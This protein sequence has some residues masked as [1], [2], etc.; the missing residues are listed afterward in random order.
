MANKKAVLSRPLPDATVPRNAFDRESMRV[1]HYSLGQIIPAWWEVMLKGSHAKF[2]RKIF[3]RTCSLKTAAFPIIDTHIEYYFVP[4]RQL[5]S[6]W[7]DFK[8]G[9][10]DVNS[11]ALV[12]SADETSLGALTMPNRVP[13]T[14]LTDIYAALLNMRT[15]SQT[16]IFGQPT[17]QNAEKLLNLLGYGY[18]DAVSTNVA[19]VNLWPLL[20]YHKI[21]YDHKRNSM[22]ENN[23]A[24][25]YNMDYLW[26]RNRD[27]KLP[28]SELYQNYQGLLT[29]HY[30]DY[31]NDYFNNIYPSLTYIQIT[32][33]YQTSSGTSGNPYINPIGIPSSV[34]GMGSSSQSVTLTGTTGSDYNRWYQD[35]SSTPL[36]PSQ[37]VST[38]SDS[39]LGTNGYNMSHDH[40]LNTTATITMQY[41][42]QSMRAAFALDKLMR[43]SAYA[44]QH[45][46]EQ[47]EARFGV[48]SKPNPN[49]SIF[50]GAYKNDIQIG[51]VTST[52][53]TSASGGDALGAIGGKGVGFDDWGKTLEFT[54]EE[55]GIVMAIQYSTI[56]SCYR[57]AGI[58][59][60]L[61]KHLP[62]DYFVPEFMNMGLEPVY[63]LEFNQSLG[64][65][66]I[67]GFR[68]RNQRYKLGID[69]S[70]GLFAYTGS[71][72]S[73]FINHTDIGRIPNVGQSGVNYA[74]FKV[75]PSDLDDITE[76]AYD[77]TMNTDQFFGQTIFGATIIQ[78]MSV[79]GQPSL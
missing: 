9:I 3:Q 20:A 44:P 79:H 58:D 11:T 55:D 4:L 27:M 23:C 76:V 30:V 45:A 57:S 65:S 10:Q 22:Y 74:W 39:H 33:P 63:G 1:Y 24:K 31:R 7:D 54:A 61:T 26:A 46:K 16:D 21:Y 53:N 12:N 35:G 66:T 43:S 19:D 48:K 51:E 6:L 72:L 29:M 28:A 59:S 25:A 34:V 78:N 73:M 42:V 71:D 68:P 8:L 75:N 47:Y 2:N 14:T 18:P 38:A 36:V 37:A 41:N 40:S 32:S 49:E 50:I 70:Y 5:W 15:N 17:E 52:S 64:Q 77:G 69:K 62:E 56:R 13:Y 67:L 60:Y